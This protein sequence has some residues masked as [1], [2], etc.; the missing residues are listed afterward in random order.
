MVL[1]LLVA[2]ISERE[3][4]LSV[5][6][7]VDAGCGATLA[8]LIV[9]FAMPS[10]FY[11]GHYAWFALFCLGGVGIFGGL[12]EWLLDPLVLPEGDHRVRISRWGL[13]NVMVSSFSIAAIVG[14]F[15]NVDYQRRLRQIGELRNEAELAALKSQLNPHIVL[16]TLNNLYALSLEGDDRTPELLLRLSDILRYSLYETEDSSA[17]LQREVELLQ[18]YVALQEVG[19]GDRAQIEFTV[20]GSP[21]DHRIAP[22]L[23]LPLV[24]NA[25]KHGSAV[26]QDEPLR[27]GFHLSIGADAI[28]FTSH[29]PFD[30]NAV[31]AGG[32]GIG[33]DNLRERLKL[34]YPDRHWLTIDSSNRE[35]HVTLIVEG[36]PA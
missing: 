9:F 8:A 28:T 18:S 20:E 16:N 13:I 33:L 19:M 25:F 26:A 2:T 36:E 1:Y 10:M 31:A 17:S 12:N 34:A 4:A 21:G 3:L 30:P 27:I 7:L 22:L 29:N 35:F 11:R 32:G 15:D 6:D 5:S 14:M 23:L 24:E